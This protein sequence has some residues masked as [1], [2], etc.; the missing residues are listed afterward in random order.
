MKHKK[1]LVA[2]ALFTVLTSAAFAAESPLRGL[3]FMA[4]SWK[5]TGEVFET[6]MAPGRM[7]SGTA[8]IQWGLDGNWLAFTYAEKKTKVAPMPVTYSGFIGYDPEIKSFVIGGV[9]SFGG[10]STASSKGLDGDSLVF[11]GP[12]HMGTMT[13]NGRDTFTRKGDRQLI[14]TGEVEMDGKWVKYTEEKCMK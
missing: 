6:P 12:W 5:C 2:A 11:T 13:T 1:A 10:Y 9:D 14:H 7:T 8:E 3:D 4:G